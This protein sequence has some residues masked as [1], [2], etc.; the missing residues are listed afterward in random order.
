MREPV[1]L[2]E[3]IYFVQLL[4]LV[5]VADDSAGS[6]AESRTLV[7]D[8]DFQGNVQHGWLLIIPVDEVAPAAIPP[9]KLL[10][11]EETTDGFF[12][13][14]AGPGESVWS[15]PGENQA[16]EWELVPDKLLRRGDADAE[17]ADILLGRRKGALP[18]DLIEVGQP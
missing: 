13:L 16:P 10:G 15:L 9:L 2:K 17:M 8:W 7:N 3:L 1:A 14:G 11:F 12:V 5:R 4:H 6:P 18:F